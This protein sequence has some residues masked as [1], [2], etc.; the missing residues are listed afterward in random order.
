MLNG[1][2]LGAGAVLGAGALLPE[3]REVPEGML[4]LGIP[5]RV[6]GP[7]GAAGMVGNAAHYV[8]NAERYRAELEQVQP[9]GV[10]E[11]QP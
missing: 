7:V 4:A 5:A 9:A 11:A 2:R 3:G 10:L 8:R 1:S 6:V